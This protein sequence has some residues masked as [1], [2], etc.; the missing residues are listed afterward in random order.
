MNIDHK[1]A[2][3]L[4]ERFENIFKEQDFLTSVRIMAGLEYVPEYRL[5]VL[6][7]AMRKIKDGKV[8]NRAE[9]TRQEYLPALLV[10]ALLSCTDEEFRKVCISYYFS[11]IRHCRREDLFGGVHYD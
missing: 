1:K 2:Y 9:Y 8:D 7:A 6:V 5:C 11:W 3:A 4:E 10:D